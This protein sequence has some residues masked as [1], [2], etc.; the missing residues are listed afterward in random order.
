VLIKALLAQNTHSQKIASRIASIGISSLYLERAAYPK[1]GLVS[2][3]D[4]GSHSDM[5]AYTFFR[6]IFALG[7]YFK[8]IAS[9]ASRQIEF[10]SLQKIGI[11]AE[12]RMLKA[13][14]GINTH[15]GAIFNLG[16]LSAAAAYRL[17]GR[18]YRNET[19]GDIVRVEWGP[20]IMLTCSQK[21]SHG[22][23]VRTRYGAGGARGEAALG[24][25]H[26]FA[27]G[28]P[29]F[30]QTLRK[31]SDL[32]MAEMQC[33]FTLMAVLVD[34]NLLYRGGPSGLDFAQKK[35]KIFLEN[36]G[37][38]QP[39][40]KAQAISIHHEFIIQNLSPGGSADLLAATLFVAGVDRLNGCRSYSL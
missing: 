15:R 29:S 10:D 27:I 16:L 8:D 40:W 18:S 22:Q 31:T 20:Q 33:F 2:F 12:S 24:F 13:T 25:P 3:I 5:N 30:Q 35:A 6:S 34:T 1:P 9:V 14:A 23:D 37:V 32:H 4:C 19:L 28:L 17:A 7:P 38:L 21:T 36:G 11:M 39:D 26:L